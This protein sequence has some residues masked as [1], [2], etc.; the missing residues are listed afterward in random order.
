MSNL[1][2][3]ENELRFIENEVQKKYPN[4][5]EVFTYFT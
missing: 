3:L 2:A 5:K 1:E 4:L